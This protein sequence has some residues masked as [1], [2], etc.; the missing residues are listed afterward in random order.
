MKNYVQKGDVLPFVTGEDLVSGQGL[1]IE[2]T[3]G[4]VALTTSTGE[5]NELALVGVYSLPMAAV[6]AL[7]F[8]RAYWDDTNKVVTNVASGNTLI[9]KFAEGGASVAELPIRLGT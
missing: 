8:E 6:T 5:E 2:D 7:Q 9:G 4:V 3:F 1:L